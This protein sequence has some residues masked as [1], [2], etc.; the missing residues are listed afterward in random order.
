M[1]GHITSLVAFCMFLPCAV[2]AAM[3]SAR[4]YSEAGN[5]FLE[6]D[7]IK[8]QLT[9]TTKD[10]EPAL[11]PDGSFVVFTRQGR[12][13]S[14][15]DDDQ[16]CNASSKA[17]ELHKINVNGNNDKVLLRGQKGNSGQQVCGFHA[18]QFSSDGQSLY[19]LSPGWTTSGALHVYDMRKQSEHFMMPAND[20]LVLSFCKNKYKD[21]LAIQDH[22]YFV[23][24]GSYDW[25]WLYDPTGKKEIGPLGEFENSNDAVKQAHEDWCSS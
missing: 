21:Y 1:K 3:E 8:T 13:S 7:G 20:V 6:R 23:F 17:D 12:A 22:R 11:S 25:Y 2:G 10:V 24:G 16:S 9:K 4:V 15:T 14:S 5:I 19:F 18:K